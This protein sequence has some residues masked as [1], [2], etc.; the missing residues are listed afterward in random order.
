MRHLYYLGLGSNLGNGTENLHRA[1][2]LLNERAGVLV[3]ASAFIESEPWGFESCHRFTNAVVAVASDF[4]PMQMLDVTQQ[5]ERDMGRTHKHKP[6]ESYTDRII[7]IDLLE[8]DGESIDNERLTLPH[9]LI[10]ERDF[11]RLPLAECKREVQNI[12]NTN[13]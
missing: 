8:Y 12:N 2:E 6:G 7:D 10:E 9:P 3:A 13:K 5:I 4:E 1:I 11:V